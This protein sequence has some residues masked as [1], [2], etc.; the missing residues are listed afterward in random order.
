MNPKVLIQTELGAIE[1]EVYLHQAPITAANF[2]H[3]VDE[4]RFAGATFYRA[5]RLDNQAQ[6]P[7][8]IEVI[9]G[10]LGMEPHS[11]KLPPIAHETTVQ[12]GL[13][14]LDGTVS[15]GRL[16]PGS[17]HSE[18]FICI[19][20][21]PELDFGG[22]RYPDGQ[23]FA[24]FARVTSGMEVV[25]AIQAKP[26]GGDTPPVQGQWIVEPVKIVQVSRLV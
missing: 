6:S 7:V 24:A 25:R 14:H 26:S 21:Q 13:K 16:E 2:L 18:F 15:M 12:T 17:A 5:V 8:K 23:G 10:G 9:Q 3:Y 19:G 20:D 22:G 4:G 11:A 1:V